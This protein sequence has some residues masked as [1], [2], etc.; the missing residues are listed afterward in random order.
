MKANYQRGGQGVNQAG[1]MKQIQKMQEEMEAKQ[2][3]VQDR[4]SVV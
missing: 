2:A 3:E 1:M 4:K